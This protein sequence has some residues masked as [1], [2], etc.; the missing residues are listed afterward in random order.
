MAT[1][2]YNDQ[3]KIT[4]LVAM[5]FLQLLLR[6]FEGR[7]LQSLHLDFVKSARLRLS[8]RRLVGNVLGY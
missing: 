8:R 1:L 4:V 3:Q 2:R 6:S 5:A 7:I